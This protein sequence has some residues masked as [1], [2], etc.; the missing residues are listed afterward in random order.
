MRPMLACNAPDNLNSLPYPLLSS[1]KLDGIRCIIKGGAALS[2]ALKPIRN[3]Y[4]QSILG[5]PELNGLDGEL[6]VGDPTARDCMRSTN[7]GVMSAGG[8]PDFTFYVFDI[9]NRPGRGY[10]EVLTHLIGLPKYPHV[11]LLPQHLCVNAFNV[12]KHE[13]QALDEGYEGLIIRRLEGLYKY[14]RSTLREGYLMKLKRYVQEEAVVIGYEPLYHNDNDPEL[15][16]LGYT[17]RSTAQAGKIDLPLLGALVVRG[18]YQNTL[19]TFKVGTGFTFEERATLWEQRE[20]LVDKIITYK[21][22]PMGSKD[23]PRHPVWVGFRD[24]D[25]M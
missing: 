2:R 20:S 5:R 13:Q 17:Q 7:S 16:A 23:R 21:L 6:I 25:D 15:N 18:I 19:T 12:E 9:W 8:E 10:H 11:K 1:T 22:F 4:I 3:Q 24:K 14:G